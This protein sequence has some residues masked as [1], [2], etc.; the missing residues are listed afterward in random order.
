MKIANEWVLILTRYL[1]VAS[2]LAV[3][4]GNVFVWARPVAK[5]EKVVFGGVVAVVLYRRYVLGL[6]SVR[7]LDAK[8]TITIST[9]YSAFMAIS[10]PI[11]IAILFISAY[12]TV[13]N[14]FIRDLLLVSSSCILIVIM[15]VGDVIR[16]GE[17]KVGS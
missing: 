17:R 4:Y 10:V 3:L 13:L 6:G 8:T 1:L 5:Y 2:V 14:I 7:K 12:L 11:L 15:I 9:T 16:L